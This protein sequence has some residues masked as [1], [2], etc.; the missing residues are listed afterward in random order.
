MAYR[1]ALLNFSK[2]EIAPEL[3][4]RFDLAAYQVGLRRARNI[5]IKRTG[6]VSKRMGT[7]F[8]S[9]CL[10]SVARLFPFQFSDE[11]GYALEFGQA[12]M[13]P[14]ALGGAVLEE[15]LQI[16]SITK[17]ATTTIEVNYHAYSVGDQIYIRSDDVEDFGMDSILDRWLTITAVPDGNHIVVDIDSTGFPD[18][19][20][21]VG[22]NRVGA[23]A[24]PPTPPVVPPPAVEPPPPEVGSGS[25]GGYSPPPPGS[26]LDRPVWSDEGIVGGIP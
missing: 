3:E 10:S 25:G 4:G 24:P 19:G 14:L 6:G 15:G 21:D 18:F 1:A 26:T 9:E 22:T 20:V 7:R 16:I 17:G 11:Q 23:P 13:R 12:Y 2:G 5:K 8:V